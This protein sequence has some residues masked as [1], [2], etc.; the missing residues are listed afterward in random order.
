MK[1]TGIQ[2]LLIGFGIFLI[3]PVFAYADAHEEADNPVQFEEI[4]VIS[5]VEKDTFNTPYAVSVINQEQI[6]RINAPTTPRI[7]RETVGVWAQQTTVGQGSPLLRGLTGYQALLTIDGVRLNNSTFRS[8]PN[9]YLATVSP[10]SL[11]RVEVLRGAGSMLYGSG[12]M[13][14]V[15]SMHTKDLILDDATEEWKFQSRAFG[16]FASGT[17]ERLGRVEVM[18][19]KNRLG[20]WVG[21]SARRF[22]NINPGRGYDLHYQN[23]KFEIVSD[24]PEGVPVLSR[25]TTEVPE[26]WLVESEG[27]LAWKAD[28]ADA[29]LSYKLNDTSTVNV[30]YQLWRQPQTPRY[31]KIAPRE[32]DEFFFEPQN[33]NL[34]YATYSSNPTLAAIDQ[35]RLT[36]SFHR[37]KE[38]R[39]ELKRGAT[40]RRVRTDTVSTLG[41]SAQ[42]ISSAL[43]MQRVVAGGE[44][45]FDT[46]TSQTVKTDITTGAENVDDS[47]GRF[48]DGSQF[49]D[50]NFYVQDEIRLHKMLELTLGGRYTLYNTN[51][52]LSVRSDQFSDFNESGSALTYSA[53]LVASVTNGLNVVGN[54]STSF[55]APSLND[56]TAVEVTN[57][58]I[59]SPSP[60]L[61]SETGWTAEGGLKARYPQFS[62]S[63]TVFHGRVKDLVTRVPV[64]EAYAGAPLPSLITEIQQNN[65]GIDVYVF[66]NVDEVQIQGIE[67]AGMAPIPTQEGLLVY[68]NAMFTRGEVLVINGGDPN[69]D[70]PW[71]SRM[72]REPPLNGILGIRWEPP[73]Q[74]L[75]GEFFVRGSAAQSRL[76]RS[77]IRDPR[78]PGTT[79]DT[80]AVEFDANGAAIDEGS[81]GWMT[82]NVRGGYQIAQ[83]IQLTVALENLLDQ[84]YR[85]H[86]SGISAPGFNVIASLNNV[87]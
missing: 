6:E 9:Q 74:R 3:L 40:E 39:N 68:G 5:H 65:P 53:G 58:G 77:D 86:G 87:F 62:G 52:D 47:K 82:L 41:A 32:F 4:T 80:G 85:E 81:P 63:L 67:L 30:A 78:I 59:D 48:I 54:Y 72:R 49:W 23:R 11:D 35:L 50:A 21:A 28:D 18:G 17:S 16:R 34:L 42:A 36:G 29:K 31:D 46:L 51:A 22:G 20:F 45:Y 15:I 37:Q 79:R 43:P 19:S 14:G 83:H 69:P 33:R 10:D 76:N 66:D 56:T 71:E 1:I 61:K 7:L 55:R 64:E 8:G 13:G 60:D 38:G 57:E 44:F 75:W 25:A 70:N 27:P 24:K 73:A 26:R 2:S 12:A 84:R